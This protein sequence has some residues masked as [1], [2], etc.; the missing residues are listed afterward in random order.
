MRLRAL[1]LAAFL[2]AVPATA[3]EHPVLDRLDDVGQAIR[4]CWKAP[5]GTSGSEVTV[6]M[7]FRRTGEI[8]GKPRITYSR[9]LGEMDA[10]RAFVASVLAAI[11]ACT[12]LSFSEGLGGSIAGRPFAMRF[13]SVGPGRDI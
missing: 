10:Q 4:Q 8:L 2:G 6:S 9:L 11:S 13:V 5:A 3:Q 1:A 7:S 12:P